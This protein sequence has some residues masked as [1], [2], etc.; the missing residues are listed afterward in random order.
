[1]SKTL[2]I[3]LHPMGGSG[4]RGGKSGKEPAADRK[5]E[6]RS[7]GS[8]GGYTQGEVPKVTEYRTA[9]IAERFPHQKN[10]AGSPQTRVSGYK[11]T[12]GEPDPVSRRD[13]QV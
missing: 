10:N 11:R 3:R 2:I 7:R 4:D 8:L 12:R 9:W 6:N 13:G 1:V 5:T